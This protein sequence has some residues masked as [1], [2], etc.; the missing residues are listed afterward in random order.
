MMSNRAVRPSRRCFCRNATAN[1]ESF[2]CLIASTDAAG[3]S[4]SPH[5]VERT[6]AKTITSPSR[7]TRSS[8]PWVSRT[9]F[10]RTR[11]PR[12]L[13]NDAAA[14]SARLPNQRRHTG[15][16]VSPP[17]MRLRLRGGFLLAALRRARL[18][19]SAVGARGGVFGFRLRLALAELGRLAYPVAQEIKLPPPHGAGPLDLDLGDLRRVD[20]ENALD[21]FALH[22]AAHGD[23]L[24]AALAFAGD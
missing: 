5:S 17:S 6:S 19:R 11:K 9:F 2:F 22:D 15:Q 1:S 3:R 16:R 7:A 12:D 14:R 24:P 21:A 10:A 8:S 18:G 13:R 23:R 20:E 4:T